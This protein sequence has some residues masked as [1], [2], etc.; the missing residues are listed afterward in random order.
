MA[1]RS[2][3]RIPRPRISRNRRRSAGTFARAFLRVGPDRQL[4]AFLLLAAASR[5]Q[6]PAP[7]VGPDPALP[8][9]G[10]QSPAGSATAPGGQ[11]A[12]LGT[13]TGPLRITNISL[14]LLFAVGSST[15]RDATIL[16]LKGG[17]HDPR[18]RGFTL[19]QAELQLNGEVDDWFTAQGVLVTFLSPDEGETIVEIEEAWLQSQNLPYQLQL[20]AGHYFTEFGRINPLHPHAWDWTDQPVIL[21]RVFGPEGMR[22]PGA[23]V[24]WLAPTHQ[25]LEVFGG[26]QNGNGA[27]MSSFL[28]NDEGYDERPIGGRP[29]PGD[30]LRDVRS[31]NDLVWTGRVA[32]TFELGEETRFGIGA[33]AAYGPNPTGP[34]ADTLIYGVDFAWQW[35]PLDYTPGD[36]F[37]RFQGEWIGRRFDA[38][39]QVDDSDPSSPFALPDQSLDDWGAYVYGLWGWTDGWAAGVRVEYASGS[40]ASYLGGGAFDR[41][42]DPFRTD[43]VRVSPL[44]QFQ[45]SQFSRVRLQYDYDDSD[46]LA[47]AAHSVWLGF[48]VMLGSQPPQLTGRDGLSGCGCR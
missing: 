7:A 25:Y 11:N 44:L 29:F 18:K 9:N 23:R 4:L 1:G 27:T 35:R 12:F 8:A 42:Q 37:L 48:E 32:T 47:D 16:E 21:S 19:Q 14:D 10:G 5:A 22:A 6:Q 20:K 39:A 34:D 41:S 46:H 33:S 24:A 43:R 15:E 13:Q 36:P 45:P 2:S 26:V 38:A 31:W 30:D 3:P 17:E 40:G 28:S